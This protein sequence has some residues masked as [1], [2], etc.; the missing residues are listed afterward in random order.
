MSASNEGLSLEAHKDSRQAVAACACQ[1]QR[2]EL[3]PPST[4]PLN[5]P[6]WGHQKVF[7]TGAR[8]PFHGR[9]RIEVILF[10]QFRYGRFGA[11]DG[12]PDRVSSPDAA[13]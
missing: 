7:H 3:P 2:T 8:A 10:S 9:F 4:E 6:D 13:V 11:L 12:G 5:A 1:R